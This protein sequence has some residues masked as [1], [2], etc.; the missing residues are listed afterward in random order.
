MIDKK[1]LNRLIEQFHQNSS[2]Y[3][4]PK[5]NYNEH[6][7]RIEYIDPLL[8][9]FGWDVA[10][11]NGLPPQ[12]REVIAENYS[13]KTD[14]PDYT[15]TLR[16]VAKFFIE[17]KKPAVN[18]YTENDPAYQTR[19]YGW[20]ANHQIAVLTN[21]EYLIIYD[22]C[23]VPHKNESC[24]FARYRTYHYLDYISK[25]E[26]IASILSREAVY[27]GEF[28][29]YLSEHFPS[30]DGNKQQVDAF[31]L[32][33][34]NKWRV[35]LSNELYRKGG[36][37]NSL[38]V[39]ND[40]VQEFV[41]QI[42]FLRICED[43]NLPLYY[44]LQDTIDNKSLLHTNLEKLF[45][46]ADRKYNSGLFSGE[47]VVFDLSSQVIMDIIAGLYYPQ[48]P[49]LFNIIEPNLLGKIYEA[50]LT[51]Q[52]ILLPDRTIGL[53]KKKDYANRSVVTT[54]IE[55]VRYMVEKTLS[56]ACE[57]KSPAEILNLRI[58]DIACG[59]GIYLEESFA[60]LHDYCVQYYL[61][62]GN[63]NH[64]IEIGSER[65]KL[66][67][68]EK[69]KIM[70]SCIYGIDIDI[71]AV[72]VAK[73]SLLI[74]LIENENKPSVTGTTPILP[75]LDNNIFYGNSL[76]SS[77]E[78]V[79]VNV[80]AEERVEIV[81]FDWN[82]INDGNLFDVIIGNPPYVNT[83]G[84]KSLLP[85][86]EIEA[87]KKHYITPYKQFDKY[88]VFIEQAIR[89]INANGYV[90][91]IVPNKFF[92]V[93]AG[94]RLRNLI[95]SR[96]LLVSLDDFGSAQLFE[97]KTIY[98]SIVLLQKAKKAKFVYSS[99]DSASKLWAGEQ[100][101]SIEL[102]SDVLSEL[103]WK[104]TTDKDFL[105]MLKQLD[106]ASVPILKYADIFN[107]IQTSAER[108]TPIYWF[109]SE[110]ILSENSDAIKVIKEGKT[111]TIEKPI[112]RQFFKPTKQAEKGMN[113]YSIL[114]TDKKIIFPYDSKGHLIPIHIMKTA[115]PGAYAY[116]ES[117]Y[118]RLVPRC[119][120]SKGTRDVPNATP[121]TWYQYGRTQALTAFTNTPKLI[122]GIL[123][124]EPMYV[125][126]TNDILI[127][128]GGT[129]GYCAISRKEDSPYALEYLQAWLSSPITERILEMTASDF[130]GD[131]VARG[132][133]VLSKLPFIELDFKNPSQKIIYNRVVEATREIYKINEKL[134]K[135]PAKRI[136]MTLQNQKQTLIDEIQGLIANV[137][138]LII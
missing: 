113:S 94:E 45:R 116:L 125:L 87:Y 6:S 83:A 36:R 52:L 85:H 71:H 109:T 38:E 123:S 37:Y 101:D 127:A 135:Q 55:I 100:V 115:Y 138:R 66:P 96:Q 112:L 28:D 76:I 40:V 95:A 49:Y 30:K 2:F 9:A 33:Q 26:E 12:Y 60:F 92:K 14:R 27:T 4:N 32:E 57:G 82:V 5:N 39:L 102:T 21:F 84:M 42:V 93:D 134:K 124:K 108:P 78:L 137:Y 88:F 69:K 75:N 54:P 90:C 132:T 117:F 65:Y 129:A 103:P 107:G 24:T 20:N 86:H 73:F 58:A 15:I 104:L 34:I 111:Y 99:I 131:F 105:L 120:S 70:Q 119:V 98:S 136:S 47:N 64:L 25:C 50:F 114:K 18:I 7:C 77:R 79:G 68:D 63:K 97:D 130:E 13:Q 89:K 10:N 29:R 17:A 133:F 121:N 3:K 19:K 16:G 62:S 74:K 81:Q 61:K 35:A 67:L 48:S 91:Y 59:S 1:V 51:E 23:Y 31:F 56:Q 53:S 43:K 80:S 44:K 41:N 46:D 106:K 22:T 126:D 128:S 110:E 72:E 8:K 11:E 122:V 118:D